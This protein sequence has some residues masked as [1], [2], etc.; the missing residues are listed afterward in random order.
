MRYAQ[1]NG[2]WL[3]EFDSIDLGVTEGVTT[4]GAAALSNLLDFKGFRE[5]AGYL[6][7]TIPAG[8]SITF[9]VLGVDYTGAAV[10]STGPTVTS[11]AAATPLTFA[12]GSTVYGYGYYDISGVGSGSWATRYPI[13]AFAQ[14]L[15]SVARTGGAGDAVVN[16]F[17]LQMRS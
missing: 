1:R 6:N 10:P 4:V 9:V 13:G 7:L 14:M 16:R 5:V 11:G 3:K 17:N 15:V 12:F 8:T 2:I